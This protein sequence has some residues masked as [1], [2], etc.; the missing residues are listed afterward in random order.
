MS[1][2]RDQ[3]GGRRVVVVGVV[4][5]GWVY[6]ALEG[7]QIPAGEQPADGDVMGVVG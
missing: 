2:P 1:H 5:T 7:L 3:E 6:A 4:E